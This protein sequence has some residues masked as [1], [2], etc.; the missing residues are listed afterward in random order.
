LGIGE[1][2]SW[3]ERAGQAMQSAASDVQI[4]VIPG[5]GHWLA[6][7]APREMLTALTTFLAPY[8]ATAPSG[9]PR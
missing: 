3:A 8:R 1:E 4:L 5:V 9:S 7:Q 6:E 2:K